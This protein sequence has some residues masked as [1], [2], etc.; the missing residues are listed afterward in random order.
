MIDWSCI[1]SFLISNQLIFLLFTRSKT[2]AGCWCDFASPSQ[3]SYLQTGVGNKGVGVN[4]VLPLPGHGL[5]L[6]L[7]H[8]CFTR[9]GKPVHALPLSGG[10][11][12]LGPGA[13]VTRHGA[14]EG[15]VNNDFLPLQHLGHGVHQAQG[16]LRGAG[17]DLAR[18]VD[19]NL[20][21]FL[22]Y[23][24]FDLKAVGDDSAVR[25]PFTVFLQCPVLSQRKNLLWR[26][27]TY[28]LSQIQESRGHVPF[29]EYVLGHLTEIPDDRVEKLLWVNHQCHNCHNSTLN[30]LNNRKAFF[31]RSQEF[32]SKV[33]SRNW[34]YVCLCRPC[35]IK[36]YQIIF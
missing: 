3:L 1:V 9:N 35:M 19:L 28:T 33:V 36:S 23:F 15:L 11:H 34:D 31:W 30:Q 18:G 22:Q 17:P 12:L 29:R 20:L 26:P 5:L 7:A 16:I 21:F 25:K 13:L 4:G 24:L 14:A 8:A 2:A 27:L 32:C 10:E 6:L